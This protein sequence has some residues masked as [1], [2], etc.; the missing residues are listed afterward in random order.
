[1]ILCFEAAKLLSTPKMRTTF[2]MG[3][4]WPLVHLFL[5]FLS[6]VEKNSVTSRIETRIVG[7]EGMDADH[8]TTTT[9]ES[10][11]FLSWTKILYRVLSAHALFLTSGY[12]S[13]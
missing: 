7:V 5:S 2:L 9:A 6:I 13:S 10:D 8:F 12:I 4:P 3:Q 11:L 1:M